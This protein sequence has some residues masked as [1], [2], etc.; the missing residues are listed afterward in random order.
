MSASSAGPS[1]GTAIWRGVLEVSDARR[2]ASV[3]STLA[4]RAR[5]GARR[6]IEGASAIADIEVSLSIGGWGWCDS[7]GDALARQMQV[8]VVEGRAPGGDLRY[9]KLLAVDHRQSVGRWVLVERHGH[10]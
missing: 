7:G 3:S 10:S 2:P 1:S 8:D 4:V 5:P 6:A 9:A